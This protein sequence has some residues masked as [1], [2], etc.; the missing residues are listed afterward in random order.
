VISVGALHLAIQPWRARFDVDVLDAPV[1]DVP[2]EPGLELR[3]VVGLKDLHSEGQALEH[4]VHELDSRL[5]VEA[6]ADLEHPKPRAVIDRGELVVLLPGALQ[7]SHEADVDLDPV[8][9]QGPLVPL[10]PVLVPWMAEALVALLGSEYLVAPIQHT[11]I[12]DV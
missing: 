8:A 6:V 1:Q 12:L 11:D 10:T 2:V 5:L 4:V 7:R 3:P 9:R